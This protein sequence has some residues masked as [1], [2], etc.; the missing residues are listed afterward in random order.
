MPAN[1]RRLV[2]AIA[3]SDPAEAGRLLDASPDLA[4]DSLRVGA[5]RAESGEHFIAALDC[6]AYAGDTALHFAAA[7]YRPELIRRLL[8]RGADVDARN[9]RG[10]TPLHY[11]AVGN[12]QSPRWNPEAQAGAVAALIAAG[13][14][15]NAVD[16]SGATPL[17]RAVRTRCAAAVRALLAGGADTSLVTKNGSTPA[18]LASVS[19]GR[20]GSGSPEARRQQEELLRL[21]DSRGGLP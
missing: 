5:T 13:A 20:G 21:L 12:P 19:S 14:N 4:R 11:A 6:Y 15:P 18:K 8:E 2:D 9:R 16:R 10:A 17:H 7:A 1:L 3:T